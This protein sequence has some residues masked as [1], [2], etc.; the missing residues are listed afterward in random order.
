MR[1]ESITCDRCGSTITLP[2]PSLV[3]ISIRAV[4]HRPP[5]SVGEAAETLD[6]KGD[7]CGLECARMWVCA[8][9]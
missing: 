7:F 2:S 6:V 9:L 5:K 4:N 8:T 3:Q 1:H